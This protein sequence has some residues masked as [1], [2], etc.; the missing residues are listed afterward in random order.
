AIAII[1]LQLNGTLLGVMVYS[2]PSDHV[3]EDSERTFQRLL[4]RQ[5]ALA[6]DR[7]RMHR[8]E[9]T[10]REAAERLAAAEKQARGDV[11]LLYELIASVNRLD[12]IEE[13]YAIV[14]RSVMRGTKSDRAAILLFDDEGVMRF[15]VTDGLS[16]EYKTAVEGH[17]PWTRDDYY[18]PPIAVDDTETDP[19]WIALR[20]QHREEGIRSIALVPL[21]NHQ[22]KLIGQLMLYR[23]EVRPF[24]GR[25]L[26]LT[27]TIGVHAAQA[28][29]RKR[30]ERE[31]ARAYSEERDARVLADEAT[32]AREEILSVVSHDLRNPLGA[33]LMCASALL[34]V[35]ADDS[36]GRVRKNVERIH[37][38]A[39]RMA[40][41]ISDL[42][43]FAGIEAGRIKLERREHQVEDIVSAASEMFGPI[44][45]ERGLR[46][47]MQLPPNLPVVQCDSDRAVQVLTNLVANAVKVTPKGGA[48]SIGAELNGDGVVFY[49]R[50]TGPGIEEDEM[51]NLFERHWRSKSSNY[52]GTGLGLSIARGIVSAHNGRI[53]AESR[54]GAGSTFYFSLTRRETN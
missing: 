40:R 21:I 52:K 15:Q 25:D 31:I 32:R 43:D 46:F 8:E 35:S 49:V 54:V 18:P 4:A 41:Y 19:E 48:V 45:A 22:G 17:S 33:I 1:P 7:V 16:T 24:T 2:Y 47:E 42:V 9:R 14:L 5:C 39:E 20:Q 34:H 6:F 44:A 27:S 3:F 23:N 50:D 28:V 13:V 10:I 38:Q 37:R 11:E 30:K 12:S 36:S 29:E 51:P 53:W 26:Q